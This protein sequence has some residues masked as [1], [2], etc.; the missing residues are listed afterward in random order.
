M[1]H[2]VAVDVR[3]NFPY[4]ASD[5]VFAVAPQVGSLGQAGDDIDD[6]DDYATRL[7]EVPG[8]ARVDTLTGA[9][10]AGAR[11]RAPDAASSP[12]RRA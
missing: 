5:T 11:V 2:Q 6:I 1:S 4:L 9:Y 3:E 7:S 12:V 8:V 10:V